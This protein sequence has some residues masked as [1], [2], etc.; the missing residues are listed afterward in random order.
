MVVQSGS[1]VDDEDS[2]P[3]V[4]SIVIEDDDTGER[5]AVVLY[6]RSRVTTGIGTSSDHV[7]GGSVQ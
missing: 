5:R 7:H 4:T 3:L 6:S 2:G 1:T